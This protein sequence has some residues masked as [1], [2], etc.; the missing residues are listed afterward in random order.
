[1]VGHTGRIEESVHGCR[2]DHLRATIDQ[3][4]DVEAVG[5]LT[6]LE[7]QGEREDHVRL[8]RWEAS[9]TRQFTVPC[10]ES[11]SAAGFLQ[12]RLH[13]NQRVDLVQHFF[14]LIKRN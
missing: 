10:V 12:R 2:P 11:I 9:W 7:R 5:Y 3:A 13:L 6:R 4:P 8:I 1:M 14:K